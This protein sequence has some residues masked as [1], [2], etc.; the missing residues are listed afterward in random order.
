[1]ATP[2][3]EEQAQLDQFGDSIAAKVWATELSP[4]VPAPIYLTEIDRKVTA[5][6]AQMNSAVIDTLRS[7]EFSTKTNL[8]AVS[9][10]VDAIEATVNTIAGVVSALSGGVV[11]PVSG[12]YSQ[13]AADVAWV[14]A[15]LKKFVDVQ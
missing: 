13:L 12:D 2:T 10:K 8:D 15:A 14:K 7:P 11:T 1:M 9:A 3:P 4:K 6:P 5:L